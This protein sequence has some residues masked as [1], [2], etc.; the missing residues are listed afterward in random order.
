MSQPVSLIRNALANSLGVVVAAG[1]GF[2]LTPFIIHQVGDSP[3]GVWAL[4]GAIAGYTGMLDLGLGFALVK[5]IAEYRARE[6]HYKINALVSSTFISYCILGGLGFSVLVTISHFA[7]QW[8]RLAPEVQGKIVPVFVLSGLA[9]WVALPSSIFSGMLAGYQRY[10]LLNTIGIGAAVLNAGL[11]IVWL[12]LRADI[13]TLAWIGVVITMTRA[14]LMGWQAHRLEPNLRIRPELFDSRLLT[15]AVRYGLGLFVLG[16]MVQIVWRTDNI[17]I[18]VF[19]PTYAI[20][21]YTVAFKLNH[22][23]REVVGRMG[24]VLFPTFSQL[25]A[26]QDTGETRHLLICATRLMLLIAIPM[27]IVLGTFAEALIMLWMGVEKYTVAAPVLRWLLIAIF[28]N[29]LITPCS[30][31][32][33]AVNYLGVCCFIASTEAIANV[34]ISVLL[35]QR[36]GLIGVAMGT[37]IPHALVAIL[38]VIPYTCY[39]LQLPV[40]QFL[41]AALLPH[42]LPATLTAGGAMLLTHV[43]SE[44]PFLPLAEATM[45][46]L[47]LYLLA[48]W[49]LASIHEKQ[50]VKR[51]VGRVTECFYRV[52]L[53]SQH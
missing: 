48:Y 4:V 52:S 17:V 43:R 10:D 44:W 32:L 11:T 47:G 29:L 51:V 34:I 18:G 3:Y 35:V 22:M 2:F 25:K 45:V 6:E 28:V 53:P 14:V 12:S 15:T 5:Y 7:P 21:F 13:V 27:A 30:V 39:T 37:A 46:L 40:R 49:P 36:L 8:F 31:Y 24:W 26:L 23:Y 1:I 20:T 19:L 33:Q 42:V 50:S 41:Y 9:L 16:F 38:F